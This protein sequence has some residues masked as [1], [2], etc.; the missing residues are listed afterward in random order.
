MA[1]EYDFRRKPNP[2]GDGELQ[3]LYPRIVSKGTISTAQLV[4]DISMMSTFTPGDIEGL[5]TAFEERISYYISE[6]QKKRLLHCLQSL[7]ATP[8]KG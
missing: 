1:I 7:Q 6:G 8:Q 3:P 4:R 5:L 2:K